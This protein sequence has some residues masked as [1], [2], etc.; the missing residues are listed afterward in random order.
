MLSTDRGEVLAA[1][2]SGKNSGNSEIDNMRETIGILDSVASGT[3][4]AFGTPS[5]STRSSRSTSS[6]PSAEAVIGGG[7]NGAG[8]ARDA[9]GR[10]LRVVL[11]EQHD[12]A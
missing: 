3:Y 11:F 9:A 6:G 2:V 12:L 5:T 1:H 8:I 4:T 10:G 7:I